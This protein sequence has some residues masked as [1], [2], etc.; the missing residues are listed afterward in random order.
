MTH[1]KSKIKKTLVKYRKKIFGRFRIKIYIEKIKSF[2]V[3]NLK[4]QEIA[5]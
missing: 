5:K 4:E 2:Y 1:N 3:R